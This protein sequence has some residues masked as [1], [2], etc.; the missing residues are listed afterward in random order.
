MG[1]VNDSVPEIT[2]EEALAEPIVRLVMASD[3][4][5]PEELLALRE[6]VDR[7]PTGRGG[8]ADAASKA[9]RPSPMDQQ[10]A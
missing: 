5:R 7:P 10:A 4:V 8:P 9:R 6:G 1:S 3:G 2:I